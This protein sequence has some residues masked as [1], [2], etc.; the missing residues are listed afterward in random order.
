MATEKT[1]IKKHLLR[2]MK[3]VHKQY[4]EKTHNLKTTDCAMC[5]LYRD[6]KNLSCTICPFRVFYR[7]G[8]RNCYPI[9]CSRKGEN[10]DRRTTEFKTHLKAVTEFYKR[11]IPEVEKRPE[12]ELQSKFD[13][14]FML[15]IDKEVAKEIIGYTMPRLNTQLLDN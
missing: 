1:I 7:C 15:E 8:N 9:D 3:A 4:V 14:E 13:F 11:I 12:E 5:R 2:A 10:G 6:E